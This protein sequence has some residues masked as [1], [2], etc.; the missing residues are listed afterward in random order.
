[1]KGPYKYLIIGILALVMLVLLMTMWNQYSV[2]ERFER[3]KPKGLSA[4]EINIALYQGKKVEA[5][6]YGWGI[7]G[8]PNGG[9]GYGRA[10]YTIV[11]E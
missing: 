3:T 11:K 1:M 4:L 2:I 5:V 6:G 10:Y 9:I 8:G 7:G